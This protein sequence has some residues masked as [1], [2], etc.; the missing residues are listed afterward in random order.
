MR[1]DVR[2]ARLLYAVREGNAVARI[3]ATIARFT[4]EYGGSAES[5]VAGD[6]VGGFRYNNQFIF[7]RKR[8]R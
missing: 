1:L 2:G 7:I 4:G 5:G 6:A 3:P 8:S